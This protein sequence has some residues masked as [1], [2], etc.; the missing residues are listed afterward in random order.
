M[1]PFFWSDRGKEVLLLA[2]AQ[3]NFYIRHRRATGTCPEDAE[4][5]NLRECYMLGTSTANMRIESAWMRM[6]RH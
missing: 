1:S 5:L 6:L 3:Y 2:D 4:A